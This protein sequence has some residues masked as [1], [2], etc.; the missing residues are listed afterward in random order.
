[1]HRLQYKA[2]RRSF[3]GSFS[4]A[5]ESFA[6]REGILVRMEDRDGRVGFGEIAPLVSF[7]TESFASALGVVESLGDKVQCEELLHELAGYPCTSWAIES[8]LEMIDREGGWPSLD[9]AW[10][11]CGLVAD[12]SDI[13]SVE[14]KLAMHY[15]CLKFKIGKSSVLEELN[16]LDRVIDLSDG[17]VKIRLDA[18]GSLDVRSTVAWLERAAEL[19]VEFIEQPLPVGEER[20]MRRLGADFP[21]LLALDESVRSVDDVKRWRDEQW[22]GLYVIKPSICGSLRA[23]EAELATGASDCVFSSSLET[24]IGASNAIGFALRQSGHERALGFGVDRLFADRNIGL[25]LGPFLQNDGL[26]S[27]GTLENLWNLT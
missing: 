13:V 4:N 21:T 20:E 10:P 12:L 23:M 11:I 26:A 9:Q 27:S 8:A 19:P 3:A 25:E 16:A 24:L 18:N 1:M 17:K 6:K 2:Y 22:E 14:E 7:G 5:R 15:Q